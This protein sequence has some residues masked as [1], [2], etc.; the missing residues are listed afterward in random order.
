M[1]IETPNLELDSPVETVT[2]LLFHDD[3]TIITTGILHYFDRNRYCVDVF[4]T[5]V[6][7]NLLLASAVLHLSIFY[8]FMYQH[9]LAGCEKLSRGQ[10]KNLSGRIG[11]GSVGEDI[12]L[13][14]IPDDPFQAITEIS[15]AVYT[16]SSIIIMAKFGMRLCDFLLEDT[17]QKQHLEHRNLQL[18][19][20]LFIGSQESLLALERKISARNSMLYNALSQNESRLNYQIAKAARMDSYDMRAIAPLT[21][22]FLPGTF[23]ATFFS[24]GVLTF[25]DQNAGQS[26][27]SNSMVSKAPMTV[28]WAITI[29]LTI[30]VVSTWVIWSCMHRRRD[31]AADV[32]AGEDSAIKIE[33]AKTQWRQMWGI[34]IRGAGARTNEE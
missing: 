18:L 29:P 28:Y 15:E 12:Q 16:L 31:H 14:V 21:T 8:T 13:Q 24:A 27:A 26:T 11:W 4:L 30:A 34:R 23:V 9:D 22:C 33:R 20:P 25:G 7:Q 32:E 1:M 6:K 2:L 19:K 5:S 10:V 17:D 3:Q